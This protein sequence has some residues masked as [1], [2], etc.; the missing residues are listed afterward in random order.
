MTI[1]GDVDSSS[2][3]TVPFALS[4]ITHQ[5]RVLA[6]DVAGNVA[7]PASVPVLVDNVAP[8]INF[9]N[10]PVNGTTAIYTNTFTV[11]GT[12]S[13]ASST[14]LDLGSGAQSVPVIN[15]L[16][17]RTWSSLITGTYTLRGVALDTAGNSSSVTT[18]VII[19][20]AGPELRKVFLPLIFHNFDPARDRYEEDA[21]YSAAP[22]IPPDGSLQHRNFYPVNDV[23]WARLDVPA[24]T[25]IVNTSGLAANTDTVLRLYASNGVTKLAENDDCT[26][27]TRASCLTW[28][29]SATTTLYIQIAPYNAQ[30]IGADR[31]YDLAV[32]RP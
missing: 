17:T 29:T 30:S 9:N 12:S 26:L 32:V 22:S 11:I 3:G 7:A 15:S 14:T 5:L 20:P 16:F 28:T 18:T 8:T 24:G 4:D 10:L 19:R 21:P 1:V 6:T 31:W 2:L 25:Y 27:Y 13:G 23:D